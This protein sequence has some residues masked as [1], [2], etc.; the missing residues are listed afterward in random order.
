MMPDWRRQVSQDVEVTKGGIRIAW[1][2]ME[3]PGF[4]QDGCMLDYAAISAETG[5]QPHSVAN[6]VTILRGLGHIACRG[7]KV[8]DQRLRLIRPVYQR[9]GRDVATADPDSLEA[10]TVPS[11]SDPSIQEQVVSKSTSLEQNVAPVL[12][13]TSD[14]V[15]PLAER[16]DL[17]TVSSPV[18]TPTPAGPI[19]EAGTAISMPWQPNSDDGWDR[20][21]M[22]LKLPLRCQHRACDRPTAFLCLETRKGFCRPHHRHAIIPVPLSLSELSEM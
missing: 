15:T 21:L 4:A 5:M 3:Q 17:G 9:A 10:R 1:F 12:K 11:I 7:V 13:L 16:A 14:T 22:S 20:D 18:P 8:G 19:R 6:A 2:L